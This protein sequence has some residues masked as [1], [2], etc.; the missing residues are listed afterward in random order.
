V[1]G[2]WRKWW[3]NMAKLVVEYGENRK[4]VVVEYGE[5]YFFWVY[6]LFFVI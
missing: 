1:G 5:T 6:L 3:W 4:K 2:I